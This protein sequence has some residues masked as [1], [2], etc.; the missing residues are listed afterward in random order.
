M[1]LIGKNITRLDSKE[2]VSGEAKFIDD[3]PFNGIYGLIIRSSIAHGEIE[4][5]IFDKD[6]DFS[7]FVIV[8]HKD[9][10]NNI[11]EVILKDQ[12]FL[13]EKVVKFIGE[14]ILIIGHK[15]KEKLKE[16]K[17]HIEIKYREFKPIF[18]IEDSLKADIKIFGDDN[19][20]KTIISEVG[21]TKRYFNS[22]KYKKFKRSYKTGHQEHIYLEPQGFIAFYK[23]GEIKVKGSMQCPFYVSGAIKSINDED[24]EVEPATVGGGFGGK[25]DYPSIV[26][27]Y[28][29]LL[30]KKAKESAKIIYERSEDISYTTK[31]HPSFVTYEAVIAKNKIKAIKVKLLLDSGAYASLSPVVL[32]RAITHCLGFYDI[33]NISIEAK[34]MATNT[35]PNGAFRGFGAPQVMFAIERFMDDLVKELNISPVEIRKKHLPNKKSLT[36]THALIREYKEVQNIFTKAIEFSNFEKKEAKFRVQNRKNKSV[37]KGIG[38]SLFI[39]GTGFTGGGEAFLASEVLIELQKNGKVK[40]KVASVE[41]G[42]GAVTILSQR[43]ASVLNL[44]ISMIEFATANTK[45]N[46]NSGPTVASRTAMVV[47]ELLESATVKLKKRLVNIT[48]IEFKN[49]KEYLKAVEAYFKVDDVVEFREKFEQPKDI[50]WDEENFKGQAYLKYSLGVN[51]AEV[52]VDLKTYKPKVDKIYALF[53]I[54]LAINPKLAKIQTQGGMMQALGYALMEKIIHKNGRVQ[55]ANLSSYLI[56]MASD[57]PKMKIE[58][59][60]TNSSPKGLGELPMNGT[61]PA[62]ANAI[63]NALGVEFDSLPITPETIMEKLNEN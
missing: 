21:D 6:F 25:E 12:P 32:E 61:A 40:I 35:P 34:A 60:N 37:K 2:K 45:Y 47:G 44:P 26:G 52:S 49:K 57:V 62:I 51:V 18:S 48:H 31:R 50:F 24:I 1:K 20:F 17:K 53:D 55:N 58:F 28:S 33:E 15:R 13:S 19:S 11:N 22:N 59:I 7:N 30:A 29:Y 8:S 5:I 23:D 39:H 4:K 27:A 43:V 54:G 38:I 63:S 9:M 3:Y 16:A 14:P 36:S 56:P 42:Q 46:L 41:I 10:K